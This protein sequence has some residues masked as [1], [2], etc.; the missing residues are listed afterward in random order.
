MFI[1]Q[2]TVI[3][4][5]IDTHMVFNLQIGVNLN[6]INKLYNICVF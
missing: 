5:I 1:C 3:I 6:Q 2:N 4:Q